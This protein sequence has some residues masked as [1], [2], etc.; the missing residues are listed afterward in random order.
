MIATNT[1]T[2][3][4]SEGSDHVFTTLP[5]AVA[6]PAC[7]NADSQV[8]PSA[9][10]PDCRAY[11]YVTPG[12]NSS[13]PPTG[14]P[15][16]TVEGLRG[17]GGAIAF[18][19][20]DAPEDAEGS[21]AV[22]NTVLAQ[23]GTSG[24]STKSLSAPTL[25]GSGTYFGTSRS[26]V[27][28]SSDL[29]QSVLWTPQP[30][31]GASSPSG[32]NLY[33]RRANGSFVA[34]TTA[35]D[36]KFSD[37]GELSGA[38]QDF[39]RLFIVSTVKQ[40]SS[41]PVNGGN[42]YEWADGDLK[43]VTILPGPGKEPA[44][45]GGTLPQGAL[46]AVSDDGGEVLFK[47]VGLPGLYLRSGG[48]NSALVS[49]SKKSTPDPNP[50]AP[51]VSV[52]ISADGSTVLFTSRS[53]L[54]E[55]ANT[56]RTLGVS[57][58]QGNDLYSYDVGTGELT[59]LTVAD[60]P[61]DAAAGADVEQVVGASRDASYVYFIATGNLAEGATSGERNLYVAHEGQID[62][63]GTNP[64]GSSGQGY[65][66]YVTPNGLHAAFMS[67]EGQTGYDNA[68]Q[69]EV[70]KFTYGSGVECASCR[71]SGEPPTGG[72]SIV[73][74][75]LSDDGSRLFY[76]SNDAVITQAQSGLSNV[77]EYEEGQV[78][79]LTPGDGVTSLLAGASATGDDVFIATFEELSPR[80]QGAAFGIYDA[81]VEADV[82][83]G[84]APFECQGE[85]CRG[86]ATKPPQPA[87]PGTAKFEAPGTVAAPKSKTVG[88]P[89]V[90]VRITVPERGEL[91]VLGRGLTP[92][93]Q[94]ASGAE[95]VTLSLTAKADKRRLK[96]GFF[97]TAAEVLFTSSS[98][99]LS[100][101]EISLKFKATDRKNGK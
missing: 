9:N 84:E 55:N 58:D 91:S 61:A 7:L 27:G 1:Q 62:F 101:A 83:P 78:H 16:M 66:F 48:E 67:T 30:L 64:T 36:P 52:G 26:T 12:L 82:P 6:P 2:G 35:G 39:T 53:E 93:K 5:A 19:S 17:D 99:A 32:T 80:S 79:L 60:D 45:N 97:K 13:A 92:V 22:T 100:R 88:A 21:T 38:S 65:P 40:L 89:K 41:D 46:P 54:T 75:A 3:E 10:L 68:G 15:E 70:Y 37:G 77:F 33:L 23:R 47:A 18:V 87:S 25:V 49:T 42:T 44:P 95:I 90:K 57:N 43:L 71:P 63:I 51:A 24:W 69:D 96:K 4:E 85:G 31:A 86:L 74:R 81:R 59:D 50:V 76:Q 73:G 34:L 56:G 20:G 28:L 94:A 98:G 11:E 72:A 8:G 14:W 29:S